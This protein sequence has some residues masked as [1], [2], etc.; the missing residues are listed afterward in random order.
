MLFMIQSFTFYSFLPRISFVYFSSI[1]ALCIAKVTLKI[2]KELNE[3]T[4]CVACICCRGSSLLLAAGRPDPGGGD[5]LPPSSQA[6]GQAKGEV[7]S[8]GEIIKVDELLSYVL[9]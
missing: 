1:L 9:K 5:K 7:T 6:P 2:V 4:P 8:T 3:K